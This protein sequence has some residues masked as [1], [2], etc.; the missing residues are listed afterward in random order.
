MA[1]TKK[2]VAAPAK[3]RTD[4]KIGTRVK[5]TRKNGLSKGY[6]A[7]LHDDPSKCVRHTS[8]GA[9]VSVNVGTPKEPDVREFRPAAVKGY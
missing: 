2:T 4:Y 7:P 6:T 1:T 8:T 3:P 5:V 9:F